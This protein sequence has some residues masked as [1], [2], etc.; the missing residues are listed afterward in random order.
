MGTEQTLGEG[1]GDGDFGA[2]V[3]YNSTLGLQTEATDAPPRDQGYHLPKAEHED[4]KFSRRRHSSN[5]AI[6][7]RAWIVTPGTSS[8][9]RF[10][11]GGT[12]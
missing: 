7:K 11:N 12:R 5:E 2:R 4:I 8:A 1:T 6:E 10:H 3:I 9:T